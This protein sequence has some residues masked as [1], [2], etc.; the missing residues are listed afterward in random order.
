MKRMTKIMMAATFTIG[1]LA[2]GCQTTTSLTA[3]VNQPVT[4][5]A[6]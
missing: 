1:T 3:P 6:L 5:E 2:A 4:S